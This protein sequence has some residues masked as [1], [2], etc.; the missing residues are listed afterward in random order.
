MAPRRM[1]FCPDAVERLP[2]YGSERV[3]SF[4]QETWGDCFKELFP[5]CG[6][7][8]R[9]GFCHAKMLQLL[10]GTGGAGAGGRLSGRLGLGA[11]GA[12]VP[13]AH[14]DGQ[15][16]QR[17]C[18]SSQSLD[19]NGIRVNDL[20]TGEQCEQTHNALFVSDSWVP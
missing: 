9:S 4:P 17:T 16:L 11:G 15:P 1:L 13:P 6:L 18:Y 14:C 3:L 5:P 12:S 7:R 20:G 8:G 10:Y 2:R 19:N